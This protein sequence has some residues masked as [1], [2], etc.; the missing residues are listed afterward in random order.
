M[1][2]DLHAALEEEPLDCPWCKI[3]DLL[4]ELEAH[5]G[6]LEIA[7]A[8]EDGFGEDFELLIDQGLIVKAKPTEDF[9]AEWG[10]DS[11][12]YVFTWNAHEF[13]PVE[14]EE[15]VGVRVIATISNGT[16]EWK[17]KHTL[18]NVDTIEAEMLH[19]VTNYNIEEAFRYG[20]TARLR[21][22][23]SVRVE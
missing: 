10:D 7:C 3:S 6:F 17:E 4:T 16:S 18:K 20:D 8:P 23:V 1:R 14:E 19:M 11:Y 22:V 21:Q 5:R 15:E 2:C 9:I 13:E 12:M